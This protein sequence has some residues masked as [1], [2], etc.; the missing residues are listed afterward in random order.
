MKFSPSHLSPFCPSLIVD[1]GSQALLG[2]VYSGDWLA[3]I[4][5]AYAFFTTLTFSKRFEINELF[6]V[7]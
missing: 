3:F 2:I 6:L 1:G 4:K 5:E 7:L